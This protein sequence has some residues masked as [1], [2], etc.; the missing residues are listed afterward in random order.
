MLTEVGD[1]TGIKEIESPELTLE[2]KKKTAKRISCSWWERGRRLTWI[3]KGYR[4]VFKC[5]RTDIL[6][7]KR[8]TSD[9]VFGFI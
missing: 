7:V 6:P 5:K 2:E 4:K 3:C 8:K 9:K 1:N